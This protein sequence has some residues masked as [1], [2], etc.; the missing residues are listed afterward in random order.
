M[1]AIRFHTPHYA[2]IREALPINSPGLI[3]CAQTEE[4]R[5]VG[6]D[7]QEELHWSV[8]ARKSSAIGEPVDKIDR[9]KRLAGCSGESEPVYDD[10]R[11]LHAVGQRR[12]NG[13]DSNEVLI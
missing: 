3:I 4:F 1:A 11:P 12:R 9:V 8:R 6:I 7:R 10:V 2:A 5:R 13:Q